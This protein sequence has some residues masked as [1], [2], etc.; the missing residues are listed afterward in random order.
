MR[1]MRKDTTVALNAIT[2]FDPVVGPI[3]CPTCKFE[4]TNPTTHGW[5]K[6]DFGVHTGWKTQLI[7]CPDCSDQANAR[8]K[9]VEIAR[10]MGQAHIPPRYQDWSFASTPTDVDT[11]AKERAI[12][13]ANRR[14]P[15][16]ALYLYGPAGRGKTGLAISIIQA[17]MRRGEDA[18][19]IR[20]LDLME[21]LKEAIR[22]GTHEG[23]DLLQLCK[24]VTW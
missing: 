20:S 13:F 21:R 7:P 5:L 8:R 3:I 2:N 18:V 17:V 12:F 23:D 6:G 16:T 24:T 11:S 14:T 19:F 9:S 10:L 15:K 22:R 4:L 1:H